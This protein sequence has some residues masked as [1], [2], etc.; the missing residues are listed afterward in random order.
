VRLPVRRKLRVVAEVRDPGVAPALEEPIRF[1]LL[2]R[3]VAPEQEH[4]TSASGEDARCRKTGQPCSD[5]DDID[6]FRGHIST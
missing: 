3:P 2:C 4:A 5:H 6:C 1:A